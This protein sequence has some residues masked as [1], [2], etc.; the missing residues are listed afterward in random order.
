MAI[1]LGA[2]FPTRDM[3]AD[4]VAIRDWAQ[5]AEGMGFDY[6]EVSDHVLGADRAALPGFEGP[7]DLND[8]FHETFATLAYIAAVT[9]KVS[10]ATGILI[11]PQRQAALVAKQA[12]QVDILCGGRLRLGVGVGWNPVEYEALGQEWKTRGRRQAEQVDLMNRL[13]SQRAVSFDGEFHRVSHAGLNPPSIQRPIPIWFGGRSDA[14]LRR[15]AKLGQGWMPLGDPDEKLKAELDALRRYLREA[16]RDPGA[17]GIECWIRTPNATPE[18]WRASADRWRAL[19]T[20]HFTAYTSGRPIRPI[21]V[22]LDEMKR[23]VEVMRP[24]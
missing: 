1:Q 14:T 23:F 22:H 6:I 18:A 7:Y 4:R 21:D 9:E 12:A 17:F 11:L 20:T 8:S 19:G 2:Y 3:P 24:R 15:T 16:G 13:W 10:L 5:A